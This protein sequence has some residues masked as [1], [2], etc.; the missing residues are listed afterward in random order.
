MSIGAF[1]GQVLIYGKFLLVYCKFVMQY[2]GIT[3]KLLNMSGDV[4]KDIF[5]V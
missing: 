3:D 5:D 4:G 2:E 1:Q